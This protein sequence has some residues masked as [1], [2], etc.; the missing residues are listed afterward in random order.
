MIPYLLYGVSSSA[1]ASSAGSTALPPFALF[2]IT[3]G[4][5]AGPSQE[6]R[7]GG[8]AV[9]GRRRR[10]EDLLWQRQ[11]EETRRKEIEA[12]ETPLTKPKAP[13]RAPSKPAPSPVLPVAEIAKSL[14]SLAKVAKIDLVQS[15]RLDPVE[16]TD[17]DELVMV[18]VQLLLAE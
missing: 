13:K 2:G 17:E 18:L 16:A 15:P 14:G 9:V 11:L 8:G 5:G 12:K 1:G 7:H 6:A 10:Y 4:V 3:D